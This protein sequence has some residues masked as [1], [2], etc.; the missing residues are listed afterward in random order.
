MLQKVT[1]TYQRPRQKAAFLQVPATDGGAPVSTAIH[2]IEKFI[3]LCYS[4]VRGL[5][6]FTGPATPSHKYINASFSLCILNLVF[7]ANCSGYFIFVKIIQ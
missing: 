7:A 1:R 4:T 6:R 2:G 5:S 3:Q